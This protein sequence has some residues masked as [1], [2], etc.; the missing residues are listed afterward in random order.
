MGSS[1]RITRPQF[2]RSTLGAITLGCA[3]IAGCLIESRVKA[4]EASQ[5][6]TH[7]PAGHIPVAQGA[8]KL[9][10]FA[11]DE[12]GRLLAGVKGP[13]ESMLRVFEPSG[14]KVDEWPL[15]VA[16]EA[17][18]VLADGKVIVGGEGTLIVVDRHGKEVLKG[19]APHMRHAADT[20]RHIQTRVREQRT[21]GADV[22]LRK[23]VE[24]YRKR[25]ASM[26]RALAGVDEALVA[27]DQRESR[28]ESTD[29]RLKIAEERESLHKRR[30]TCLKLQLNLEA[31]IRDPLRLKTKAQRKPAG[32][33]PAEP[34]LEQLVA[35]QG[36]IASISASKSDIVYACSSSTGSGYDVWRTDL[37]FGHPVKIGQS[38][39][40]CCGQM[41]VQ[42]N[43]NGIYVAENTRHRVRCYT[44][45]GKEQFEFGSR[46]R[47]QPDSFEG[48]CNPMNVAF[49]V[50][51]SV[52]TAE[53][54]IGRIKRF[55]RDGR[56]Q[57]LIGKVDLVPGCKKVAISVS[58][59]G[60][61]IY[62]LDI[63]RGHIVT[64]VQQPRQADARGRSETD[65]VLATVK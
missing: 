14:E 55:T 56:F 31:N 15:P 54:G 27:L 22:K 18:N 4:D 16:P 7:R 52:Y 11:V 51:G 39:R 48:C 62:M 42:A 53:A 17:V 3:T 45:D 47:D 65:V 20:A 30:A 33:P 44:R 19:P 21:A 59:A 8:E 50:D 10:T 46:E 38:L 35:T 13:Q 6:A 58:P 9:T 43:E 24:I 28:A 23:Q 1:R 41:D 57:Q 64:M 60:D 34:S 25:L 61:V 29:E 12:M 5:V 26:E 2:V 40:G 49:G 37:D 32:P 63:T 36:R